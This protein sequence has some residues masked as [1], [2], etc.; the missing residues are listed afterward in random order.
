[1]RRLPAAEHQ[2]AGAVAPPPGPPPLGDFPPQR[3]TWVCRSDGRIAW[4]DRLKR[5][6]LRHAAGSISV[7]RHRRGSRHPFGGDHQ[8]LPRRPLRLLPGVERTRDLVFVGRLVSDE[9]CDLLLTPSPSWRERV[10]ARSAVVGEGAERPGSRSRRHASAWRTR[11]NSPAPAAAKSW[12]ASSTGTASWWFRP[13]T[14]SPSD[15]RPGEIACGL[16]VGGRLVRGRA[17][18]CHRPLRPDVPVTATPPAWSR[19]W[20][21]CCAATRSPAT[22]CNGR[23]T[24]WPGAFDHKI[25][26]AY[27]RVCEEA[28]RGRS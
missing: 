2:P 4:Q 15:R 3:A 9:G 27:L 28:F 5:R 16:P 1:M 25:A 21:A 6:L 10:A 26:Q 8:R 18:G 23:R 20:T 14:K 19:S 17:R 11:W 12:W 13:A 7:P 22:S 24:T